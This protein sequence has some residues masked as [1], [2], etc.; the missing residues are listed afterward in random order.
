MVSSG[1]NCIK[2]IEGLNKL[3]HLD[4]LDLHSNNI[5]QIENLNHLHVSMLCILI[6]P[7]YHISFSKCDTANSRSMCMHACF[8]LTNVF[9]TVVCLYMFVN[10]VLENSKLVG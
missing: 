8:D 5:T 3:E 6:C 7:D 10:S 4:V 9:G 1:K 2:K